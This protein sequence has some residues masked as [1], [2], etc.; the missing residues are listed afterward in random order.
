MPKDKGFLKKIDVSENL[1]FEHVVFLRIHLGFE[2]NIL[3]IH[4]ERFTMNKQYFVDRIPG[5]A[6]SIRLCVFKTMRRAPLE[7][8]GP[9][10]SAI[11]LVTPLPN[12]KCNANA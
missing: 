1:F 10:S 4:G 7:T 2:Q 11:N 5:P 3:L 8:D 9:A 6:C 12:D